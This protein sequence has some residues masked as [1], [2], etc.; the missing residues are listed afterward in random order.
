MNELVVLKNKEAVCSSVQVAEYFEKRHN[1]TV[2]AIENLI[3]QNC[4]MKSMF[5]QSKYL[6][7]NGQEYKMYFM[8]RDGFSLLVMGFTGKKALEWKLLYIKAFN[9]ME[10]ILMERQTTEWQLTRKQG[11]IT[12]KSETDIIKEL[13]EYAKGQGSKN[14]D[15]LYMTYS[16]LANK[17]VGISARDSANISQLNNLTLA[18]N[19]N[20]NT[21]LDNFYKV[22]T[23]Y[24]AGVL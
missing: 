24:S 9:E 19:W 3:T 18:E 17:M 7:K 23:R 5:H 22:S 13:V 16:K 1:D 8:N 6:S 15:K 12:R 4:V 11:K 10:K 2:R 21:F 20:V 14:A